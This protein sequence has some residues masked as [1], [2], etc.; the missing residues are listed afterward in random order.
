MSEEEGRGVVIKKGKKVAEFFEILKSHFDTKFV[1]KLTRYQSV[2]PFQYDPP[3]SSII[4]TSGFTTTHVMVSVRY[5]IT[6]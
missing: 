5:P 3:P 4:Y 6:Y 2:K 1:I